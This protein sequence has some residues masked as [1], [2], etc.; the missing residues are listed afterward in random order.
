MPV[1]YKLAADVAQRIEDLFRSGLGVNEIFDTLQSK[2]SKRQLQ[3]MNR[4]LQDFDTVAPAPI[5]KQGRPRSIT[6]EAQDGIV[7]FLIEY[8]KQATVEEV[9][10][11]IEEEFDIQV[12]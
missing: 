10:I 11:F 2:V 6:P 8:D 7:E 4:R 12:S 1:H 5:C 3:R 9:R